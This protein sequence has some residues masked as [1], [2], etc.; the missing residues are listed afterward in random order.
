MFVWSLNGSKASALN[1]DYLDYYNTDHAKWG[2]IAGC[3][4]RFDYYRELSIAKVLREICY[5]Q[6]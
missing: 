5:L 4:L 1:F 2:Q 6:K 3:V